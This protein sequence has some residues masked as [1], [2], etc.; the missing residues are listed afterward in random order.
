[1]SVKK[2]HNLVGRD[3]VHVVLM[4]TKYF[5]RNNPVGNFQHLTNP[6]YKTQNRLRLMSRRGVFKIQSNLRGL[7]VNRGYH[8]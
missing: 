8:V 3:D 4:N 5:K 7:D 6:T 1:M 2:S